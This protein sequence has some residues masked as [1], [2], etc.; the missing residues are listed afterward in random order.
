M[1]E[2]FGCDFVVAVGAVAMES[3]SEARYADAFACRLRLLRKFA[4]VVEDVTF[5]FVEVAA[6][7][8]T[9]DTMA[10]YDSCM[11]VEAHP[12]AVHSVV[13]AVVLAI[14]V[15]ALFRPVPYPLRCSYSAQ[16]LHNSLRSL[17][18]NRRFPLGKVL[19]QRMA[20]VSFA[21]DTHGTVDCVLGF[22]PDQ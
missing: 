19:R 14:V 12:D 20:A 6:V 13:V 1:L 11:V 4:G 7:E 18:Q 8:V 16:Y 10:E 17:R 9:T 21:T 5:G 2:L 3:W 22:R 15:V